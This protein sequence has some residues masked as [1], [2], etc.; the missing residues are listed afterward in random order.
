MKETNSPIFST[1]FLALLICL[2]FAGMPQGKKL[3][4]IK[5]SDNNSFLVTEDNNPFFWLGD[6]AWELF[7]RLDKE[8]TIHYLKDRADKGFTVIQAVVLAELDG[9][10]EPNAYGDLPLINNDPTKLNEKYFTHVDFVIDQAQKMGLYI[11][12]LPTWGDK[13]NKAWGKGPEVFTPQNAAAYGELLAKRYAEQNNIIW[14]L[15]GDRWPDDD[16]DKEIIRAMARGI[17]ISGSVHLITYHPAGGQIATDFF[18]ESWLDVNMFQ[19]GHSRTA[20][21]YELVWKSRT[22]KPS[23]PVINGEPRYENHPNRFKPDIYGW[24]D[25]TD[26]RTSA[27]WTMLSGAA[28]YTYGCH[29]IWQMFDEHREPISGARTSWREAMHL[30]GSRQLMYMKAL[31]VSFPF[32]EM[33]NDQSLILNENPQDSAFIISSISNKRDF[34]LIYSPMGKSIKVDL[35]KIKSEKVKAF[36]YNPRDGKSKWIGDFKVSETPEF[37]PWSTGRGSDFVLVIMDEGA[38]YNIP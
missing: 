18:N 24:M 7:H 33:N 3:P 2:P 34:M 27:Y 10:R 29:D 20:Q 8:E 37:Q 11:G 28:G 38:S 36:W 6:T 15:G 4:L 13:F 16:E 22:E 5:V 32:Q 21:D 9:L 30:P 12:L 26:V 25:D 14:I 17:R 23:R 19:T 1:C 31:L 35:S